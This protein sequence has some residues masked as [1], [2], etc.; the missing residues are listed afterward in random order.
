[1]V[2]NSFELYHN[3]TSSSAQFWAADKWMSGGYL[4]KSVCLNYLQP[5][6]KHYGMSVRL[7]INNMDNLY[8]GYQF[9][10][11]YIHLTGGTWYSLDIIWTK[12]VIL[13]RIY[14]ALS[15]VVKYIY[16]FHRIYSFK[17][18]SKNIFGPPILK[19]GR[20]KNILCDSSSR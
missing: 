6:V 7:L 10:K 5:T 11:F 12:T 20:P 19:N 3:G 8:Q 16:I 2:D 4:T 15:C 18:C 9:R 13:H 1:M 17:L 14:I